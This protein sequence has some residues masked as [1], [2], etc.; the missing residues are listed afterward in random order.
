MSPAITVSLVGGL[1]NQ[2]FAYYAGVA[3]ARRR[4]VGLVVDTTWAAH[5]VSIRSFELGGRW[6]N[7]PPAAL[8]PLWGRS[9]IGYRALMRAAR[10]APFT[11]D[12]LKIYDSPVVGHDPALLQQPAGSRIRGYFQ[13]WQFVAEAVAGGSP[14]R[15]RLREESPWL[16]RMRQEAE[17]DRPLM[18]HV[19]RGDYTQHDFGL[20]GDS[21]Y[22]RA[23]TALRRQGLAGPVWVFSDE[24]ERVPEGLRSQ[25]R[26]VT[27]PVSPHEDLVLMSHGAGNVIANSTFSWWGA[28][29]NP[30]DAPVV[31]PDP[32][33]RSGAPIDG[34]S[35]P[36]WRPEAGAWEGP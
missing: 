6:I 21:Y 26:V 16:V 35:P 7:P 24:P 13:S 36:W 31:Y 15:L 25:A 17:T 12:L 11:R 18:V 34:L 5:G 9:S 23:L 4:N 27:S 30:V 20:L 29:M 33:F 28:W 14:R 19:R 8:Q 22:E 3:L 10:L 1:G 2:L 32:W